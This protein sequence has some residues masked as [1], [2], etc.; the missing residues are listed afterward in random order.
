MNKQFF[1]KSEMTKITCLLGTEYGDD[2]IL[3]GRLDDQTVFVR[4]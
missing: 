1:F 2:I 3:S 4:L